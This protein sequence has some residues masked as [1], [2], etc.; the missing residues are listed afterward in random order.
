MSGSI[1]LDLEPLD[2]L[3]FRDG[4]PFDA[5]PRATSGAPLPQTVAG[6][7]RTWLLRRTNTN[8]KALAEAIRNGASVRGGDLSTGTGTRIGRTSRRSR[9][10]VRQGWGTAGSDARHRGDR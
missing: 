9:T 6:A 3:F 2:V 10:L 4:R 8:L 7:V 5:A 1:T